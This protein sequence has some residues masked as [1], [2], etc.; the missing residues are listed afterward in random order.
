MKRIIALFLTLIC[1][2]ITFAGCEDSANKGKS[3]NS[4]NSN[5]SGVQTPATSPIEDFEFESGENGLTVTK[6]LGSAKKVVIPS[7]VDNKK[8][9]DLK[10]DVFGGNVVV[11]EIVL[12]DYMTG[13]Y[14]DCFK[15]CDSLKILTC[16]GY[17]EIDE[18]YVK[19]EYLPSNLNTMIFPSLKTVS[20]YVLQKIHSD[21]PNVNTFICNSA[22]E[23][24]TIDF[25]ESN[26]YKGEY[27]IVLPEALI[28]NIKNKTVY[29]FNQSKVYGGEDEVTERDTLDNGW[30]LDIPFESEL[31]D[32]TL[33]FVT[34]KSEI[35]SLVLAYA[36][37]SA[38][39]I[40]NKDH[41][42]TNEKYGIIDLGND[43]ESDTY[44][45][46]YEFV[47]EI[48]SG[49]SSYVSCSFYYISELYDSYDDYFCGREFY[50]NNYECTEI[51]T[52]PNLAVT[53]AFG[54]VDSITVNGTT[55]SYNHK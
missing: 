45:C 49:I 50:A 1:L 14:L 24:K 27:N 10:S 39:M 54:R 46:K 35:H 19:A 6:Y 17:T 55:Y 34:D 28:N 31:G 25:S 41:K 7:I 23:I 18:K 37:S 29:Y 16:S 15:G 36:N 11:E 53:T 3:A 43:G 44:I 8:V 26:R 30:L 48:S 4:E 12:S 32:N 22:T 20:V 52:D 42:I 5:N 47:Y 33:S 40:I 38:A 9:V 51:K 2:S 13:L 21:A